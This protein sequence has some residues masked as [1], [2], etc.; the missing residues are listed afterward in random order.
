MSEE[1]PGFSP[2]ESPCFA[3]G[4]AGFREAALTF[5]TQRS[6]ASLFFN[7]CLGRNFR[8]REGFSALSSFPH[9]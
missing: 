5:A 6:P 9:S 3:L 4:K 1:R 8:T 2:V 7:L